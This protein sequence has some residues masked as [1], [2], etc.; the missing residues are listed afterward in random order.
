MKHFQNDDEM[1][2]LMKDKLYTPVVG[3]ILDAMGFAHQFLPSLSASAPAGYENCRTSLHRVRTGRILPTES[4]SVTLP[5]ARP[6]EAKRRVF[7]YWRA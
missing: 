2:S 7:G 6:A 1:F 3:D 4:R 5:S